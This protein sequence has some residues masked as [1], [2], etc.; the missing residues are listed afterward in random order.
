MT[1]SFDRAKEALNSARVFAASVQLELQDKVAPFLAFM[2][3]ERAKA[4]ASYAD[5]GTTDMEVRQLKIAAYKAQAQSWLGVARLSTA[6]RQSLLEVME[7][8]RQKAHASY[9]DIG[10]TAKEVQSLKNSKS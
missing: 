4:D 9:E 7:E 8:Y 1:T 5:I 2:E 3:Y 6:R 10:T